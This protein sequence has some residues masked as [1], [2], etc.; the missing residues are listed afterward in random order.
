MN[1]NNGCRGIL[2]GLILGALF[3]IVVIT[4]AY[5]YNHDPD[6]RRCLIHDTIEDC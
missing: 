4:Y 6:A 2:I 3:W 1:E 5:A